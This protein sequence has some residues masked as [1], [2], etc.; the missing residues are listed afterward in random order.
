MVDLIV[1]VVFLVVFF[2]YLLKRVLKDS[3][4]IQSVEDYLFCHGENS[5]GINERSSWVTAVAS[6]FQA[7]SV[8]FVGLYFGFTYGLTMLLTAFSFALGIYYLRKSLL[9]LNKEAKQKIFTE[10]KLPYDKIYGTK[11]GTSS[12]AII[13][14]IYFTVLFSAVLEVWF[15]VSILQDLANPLLENANL[16]NG[17]ID[18]KILSYSYLFIG[19]I[20]FAYVY[21]G[22]YRAVIITDDIQLRMIFVM[23]L[24]MI[25]GVV[26][27]AINSKAVFDFKAML[28]GGGTLAA[29]PK[30]FFALM[31]GAVVL[32][33]FWQFVDPQ[34]WQR[35]RAATSEREY[36]NSLSK[37]SVWVFISWAL[38]IICGA[39]IVATNSSLELSSPASFPFIILY[40]YLKIFEMKSFH[41]LSSLALAIS[42]TGIISASIS[43]A[44][45]AIIAFISK[46]AGSNGTKSIVATR[47][48]AIVA[49]F[50]VCTV[51]AIIY[52]ISP[53]IENAIFSV[54][55]AQ[56]IFAGI[57]LKYIQTGGN[58]TIR[59]KSTSVVISIIFVTSFV[60]SVSVSFVPAVTKILPYGSFLLP[61][62]YFIIGLF[63]SKKIYA[64]NII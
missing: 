35:A 47:Q 16:Q 37:A 52:K 58:C 60:I 50:L 9:P 29:D 34:Q 8:L 27:N 63:L 15:G 44:D 10:S 26:I 5:D 57:F 56:I 2:G 21:I 59:K 64:E 19:A 62:I 14:F 4:N 24:L 49:T 53:Q 11:R 32:N 45:T 54:Y 30:Y 25:L 36:I 46:I 12:N 3:S 1:F 39:I 20:L 6:N 17:N 42:A 38:P 55:S 41:Y 23:L 51:A 61:P 48:K 7:A 43:S 18:H 40:D 31:G 22:G 13:I 28:I 33:F